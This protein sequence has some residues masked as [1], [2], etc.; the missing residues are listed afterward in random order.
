MIK[1]ITTLFLAAMMVFSFVACSASKPT[2][3]ALYDETVLTIDGKDVTYEFYRY[4]YLT[5]Y[6]TYSERDQ[7]KIIS[8]VLTKLRYDKAVDIL[9]T[10]NGLALT[11]E[12]KAEIDSMIEM[13]KTTY[14]S[15]LD[16]QLS[17]QNLT[18]DVFKETMTHMIQYNKL[19]EYFEKEENKKLDFSDSAV[20]AVLDKFDSGLHF[21]VNKGGSLSDE[22]TEKLAK[23]VYSMALVAEGFA[24]SGELFDLLDS[25]K[26]TE[27][28]ID[29]IN[30]QIS[31]G[32]S[33]DSL[34]TSLSNLTKKLG[35]LNEKLAKTDYTDGVKNDL[36]L[37]VNR[38]DDYADYVKD[39]V[40]SSVNSKD[41][42]LV[43]LINKN[44]VDG[45]SDYI[46]SKGVEIIEKNLTK[47]LQEVVANVSSYGWL[48]DEFKSAVKT[49]VATPTADSAKKLT[50]IYTSS[51]DMKK[52][53]LLTNINTV[54][55]SYTT[56]STEN[57]CYLYRDA[58][59][60]VDGLLEID[61]EFYVKASELGACFEAEKNAKDLLEKLKAGSLKANEISFEELGVLNAVV[62]DFEELIVKY[63]DGYNA[64]A[65]TQMF[66]YS[67]DELI[68]ELIPVVSKL[69]DGQMT[70]VVPSEN[71][72]HIF[73]KLAEDKEHFKTNYYAYAAIEDIITTKADT[74]EYKTTPL[75]D[76]LSVEKI[77]ELEKTLTDQLAEI[78]AANQ[79]SDGTGTDSTEA[80]D[81]STM[82]WTIVIIGGTVVVIAVLAV[83]I[84]YSSKA[85]SPAEAKKKETYKIKE[86]SNSA[87]TKEKKDVKES[88]DSKNK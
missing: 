65:E 42:Q 82:I 3:P 68:E 62:Y 31:G 81:D 35:E 60:A 1:K 11:E 7:A 86:K 20:Q 18:I 46:S 63:S 48:T 61:S 14:G 88:K 41:A 53:T 16:A 24:S 47:V 54:V 77:K 84:Y 36:D 38:I 12:E 69:T 40:I 49:F 75:Y 39:E 79:E 2:R 58:L 32:S 85:P 33:S 6:N 73:K 21:V 50:E 29:D 44:D 78:E 10:E 19:F 9:L 34:T 45:I 30:S 64:E 8:D 66:Y 22:D 28:A 13:Y 76:S 23:K 43:E 71:G 67:V 27:E 26:Q 57:A 59:S 80:E 37:Y 17:K 55:V 51:D 15:T 5:A 4:Y 83:A 72:Y 74:I 56:L 25:I 87:N 52:D 70:E